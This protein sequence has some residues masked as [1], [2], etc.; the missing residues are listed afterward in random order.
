MLHQI[1]PTTILLTTDSGSLELR[2][3]KCGDRQKF[4]RYRALAYEV[5][6]GDTLAH[7]AAGYGFM[8]AFRCAIQDQGFAHCCRE[9][10]ALHGV[11][12]DGL[13]S[14][15][16]VALLFSY[17]G[18]DGLLVQLEFPPMPSDG[19]PLSPDLDPYHYLIAVLAYRDGDI[20]R[21]KATVDQ[22]TYEEI[23]GVLRGL[24]EVAKDKSKPE[25]APQL[26]E[27][28]RAAQLADARAKLQQRLSAQQKP[29]DGVDPGLAAIQAKIKEM[30]G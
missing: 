25:A 3:L 18:G 11:D 14:A 23:T 13:D 1:T 27:E 22:L 6:Q 19:K 20:A 16:V 5:L 12:M 8:A 28:E 21:A 7:F 10:L 2:A 17:Q 26:S 4:L 30:Q 29:P 24:K 15:Q 9:M